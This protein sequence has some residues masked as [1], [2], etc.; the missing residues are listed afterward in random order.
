MYPMDISPSKRR[1]LGPID[2]NTLNTSNSSHELSKSIISP[3]GLTQLD[4]GAMKRSLGDRGIINQRQECAPNQ[5]VK[6]QRVS[7]GE[8]VHLIMTG[9][10]DTT[11]DPCDGDYKSENDNDD[12]NYINGHDSCVGHQR[13]ESPDEVSSM[14]DNSVVDTSQATTI[15]EPDVEVSVRSPPE[16]PR[17]QSSMSREEARQ[18]AEKLR[19]RLGLASYKVRT[20]QMDVPLDQLKV[21]PLMDTTRPRKL[22][23]P[24]LPPL[25]RWEE[26]PAEC[27]DSGEEHQYRP[28]ANELSTEPSCSR[29]DNL[30]QAHPPSAGTLL[31]E[32]QPT[33]TD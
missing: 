27:E 25:P 3:S 7:T 26:V 2:S 30:V 31:P 11:M 28:T 12:D 21:R 9:E 13:S 17:R 22:K 15:T 29:G 23:Q 8:D 18:K 10:Q 19:L 1:A 5:P 33:D 6:R 24:S 16:S 14:F 32:I 20:G 4:P